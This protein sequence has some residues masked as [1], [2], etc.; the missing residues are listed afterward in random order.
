M[1]ECRADRIC[2]KI[3]S[4]VRYWSRDE[5][6]EC[7]PSMVCR[8]V[9]EFGVATYHEAVDQLAVLLHKGA[10][11]IDPEKPSARNIVHEKRPPKRGLYI[12]QKEL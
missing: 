3:L 6:P 2:L 1:T 7:R 12:P 5:E 4:V 10:L 11:G 9:S 8:I